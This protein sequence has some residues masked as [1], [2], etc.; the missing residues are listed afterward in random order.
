[1]TVATTR[2][3][4]DSAATS[5]PSDAPNA[6]RDP[7]AICERCGE[8]RTGWA[9]IEVRVPVAGSMT[10]VG[11]TLKVCCYPCQQQLSASVPPGKAQAPLWSAND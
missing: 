5:R 4:A 2:V 10:G 11:R 6:L 8:L 9:R 1:M 3:M 7:K